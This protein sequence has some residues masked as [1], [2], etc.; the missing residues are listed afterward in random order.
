MVEGRRR[1]PIRPGITSTRLPKR[2]RHSSAVLA[3]LPPLRLA[4]V[5]TSAMPARRHRL[6][7]PRWAVTLS[8]TVSWLPRRKAGQADDAGTNQV[9]GP[10][11]ADRMSRRKA[12]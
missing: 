8:A 1:A 9:C 5:D 10:G 6:A 11:Q 3:G 4:L 2:R 7:A 12:A